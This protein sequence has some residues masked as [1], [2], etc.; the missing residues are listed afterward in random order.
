MTVINTTWWE[1]Q[2]LSWN[3]TQ[4]LNGSHVYAD[5]DLAASGYKKVI[6][7]LII[8][9][10]AGGNGNASIA[11]LT[12]PDSG[13]NVD[14]EELYA[15]NVAYTASADKKLSFSLD[16]LP[17]T[18][19]EIYNGNTNATVINISGYYSALKYYTV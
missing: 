15:L 18:R 10:N 9:W 4:P 11:I 16:E 6:P 19:I 12:S 7:Q 2:A 8:G 5:I 13:T 14:T 3:D 17:W 1:S